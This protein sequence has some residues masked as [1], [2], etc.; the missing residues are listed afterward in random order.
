M[1]QKNGEQAKLGAGENG[2]HEQGKPGDNAGKDQRQ[3]DE[4]AEECFAREVGAI[5]GQRS[6]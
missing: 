4:A 6:Q 1:A 5:K 3:E 2:E